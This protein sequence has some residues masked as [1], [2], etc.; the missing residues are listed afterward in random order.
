[1]NENL[2]DW[3]AEQGFF[4]T[5]TASYDPDA[6]GTTESAVGTLERLARFLLSLLRL[7]SCWW[8]IVVLAA[9]Q[10]GDN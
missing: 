10:L 7:P 3:C 8:G 4:K 2:D 9:T 1:M 6:N 5:Y